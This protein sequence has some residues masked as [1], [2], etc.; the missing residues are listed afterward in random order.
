MPSY[1]DGFA[2]KADLEGLLLIIDTLCQESY[3]L[4]VGLLFLVCNND[5]ES[6]VCM[7]WAV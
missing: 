6:K 3:R 7:K 4:I 5:L 2:Y 1:A